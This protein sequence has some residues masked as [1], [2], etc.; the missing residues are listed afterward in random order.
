M[1][2]LLNMSPIPFINNMG[3]SAFI[4]QEHSRNVVNSY[5]VNPVKAL[6]FFNNFLIK[7]SIFVI[8]APRF[9]SFFKHITS[10]ILDG[11]K[12]KMIWVNTFRIIAMMAYQKIEWIFPKSIKIRKPMRSCRESFTHSMDAMHSIALN[13]SRLPIPAFLFRF[14]IN[15]IP[16]VFNNFFFQKQIINLNA[17]NHYIFMTDA[18]VVVKCL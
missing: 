16:K 1:T 6:N 4:H 5:F 3:N 15:F 8:A 9:S 17:F 7:N 18:S 14:N 11:P 13:R 2:L 12:K 10:I